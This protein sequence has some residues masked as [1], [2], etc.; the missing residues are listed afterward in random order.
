LNRIIQSQIRNIETLFIFK[1]KGSHLLSFW[2]LFI[3]HFSPRQNTLGIKIFY[4]NF[5]IGKYLLVVLKHPA[6]FSLLTGVEQ[7]K[8]VFAGIARDRRVKPIW[9]KVQSVCNALECWF[10]A[11]L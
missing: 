7:G 10:Y 3:F 2:P 5:L 8:H 1:K 6:F 11:T 9:S 4:I